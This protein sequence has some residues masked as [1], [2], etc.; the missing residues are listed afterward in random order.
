MLAGL[1]PSDRAEALGHCSRR[2]VERGEFVCREGE[3]G[4]SLFLLEKGHALVEAIT[5][6]GNVSTFAILSPGD[7]FG[8]QALLSS[9]ERR[10]ATV[11]AIETVDL[12]YLTR[13][14][15]DRLRD[16]HPAVNR[17]LFSI[18]AA[19]M[20]DMTSQLLEALHS[21]AEQ[22]VFSR[23][24][25]L[26]DVYAD[27]D[28]NPCRIPLTQDQV[29]SLAATTRPTA[30]RVLQEAAQAGAVRLGRGYIAILDRA[31]L[32]RLASDAG[33]ER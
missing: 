6:A 22:R 23:L 29:A 10:G 17:F 9:T 21:S 18:I 3:R 13:K 20:R 27:G 7:V 15:F 8:E 25:R 4:D 26:A 31:R 24:Q 33:G 11:V 28:D 32:A 19:R 16:A 2:R 30:N 12:L 14:D 1:S 5:K